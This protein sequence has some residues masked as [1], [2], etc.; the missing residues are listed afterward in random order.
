MRN[1]NERMRAYFP[2]SGSLFNSVRALDA[3]KTNCD[4]ASPLVVESLLYVRKE[5]RERESTSYVFANAK[6]SCQMPSGINVIRSHLTGYSIQYA[7]NN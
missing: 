7:S 5:S 2:Y 1:E 3:D 6:T 4:A